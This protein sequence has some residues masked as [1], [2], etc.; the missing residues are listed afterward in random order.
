MT[1]SYVHGRRGS[2][3]RATCLLVI[4]GVLGG[5]AGTTKI[6]L[7]PELPRRTADGPFQ[8]RWA[9]QR[10]PTVVRAIGQI[11]YAVDV[12]YQI[13]LAFYGLEGEQ[14]I[15]SRGV[16]YVRSSLSYRPIP[17]VVE[18]KPTGGETSFELRVLSYQTDRIG[19]RPRM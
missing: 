18:L 14:R 1:A 12:E 6:Q 13:T 3:G 2:W 15:L 7:P 8:I 17:F 10:E 11:E 4:M 9:L 5:C 16:T 19:I